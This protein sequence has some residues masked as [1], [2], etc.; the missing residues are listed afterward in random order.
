MTL[1]SNS[2]GA[3]LGRIGVLLASLTAVGGAWWA[4]GPLVLPDAVIRLGPT[5]EMRLRATVSPRATLASAGFRIVLEHARNGTTDLDRLARHR[6]ARVRALVARLMGLVSAIAHL[7]ELVAL[8]ADAD[9]RVR[10]AAITTLLSDQ[11]K[12]GA[13]DA[14]DPSWGDAEGI[15]R[16]LQA[17]SAA[18]RTSSL[19]ALAAMSS[20]ENR[21]EARALLA[22]PDDEVRWTA[23]VALCS[24]RD[25]Q[26]DVILDAFTTLDPRLRHALSALE[27]NVTLSDDQ[28]DRW[29]KRASAP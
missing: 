25:P 14:S 29:R 23:I 1:F 3:T 17:R 24:L 20:A 12:R 11:A 5:D 6:D 22:D 2:A 19:W 8:A 4:L 7:D 16:G 9:L 10:N 28:R 26:V 21:E 18:L 27:R 15:A 13:A